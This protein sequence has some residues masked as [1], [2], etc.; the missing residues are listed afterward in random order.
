MKHAIARA[1]ADLM[2]DI[3]EVVEVEAHGVPS[4]DVEYIPPS[5]EAQ[6]LLTAI[7]EK[8]EA[9]LKDFISQ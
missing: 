9:T 6:V 2:S 7:G 5:D 4:D 8:I 1:T 3:L